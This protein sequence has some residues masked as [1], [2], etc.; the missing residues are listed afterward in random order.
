MTEQLTASHLGLPPPA[1]WTLYDADRAVGW[2]TER[3]VGFHGFADQTEAV[4]AAWVAYRALARRLARDEGRRAIPI[5]TEPLSVRRD[6]DREL[7]V[8]GGRAIA[9]LVRPGEQSPTGSASFGFEVEISPPTD[10]LRVRSLARL[11]YRTLRRSGLRW[12]LWRPVAPGAR[13]TALEEAGEAGEAAWPKPLRPSTW[14]A[15]GLASL[16]LLVLALL[17]PKGLGV[18]L[19][20]AGMVALVVFSVAAMTGRWLPQRLIRVW[21][22]ES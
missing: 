19:T 16:S 6:G 18:G 11:M 17:V 8:A 21:E 3:S 20:V 2:T 9:T 5:D 10:E 1:Q 15:L 14:I 12:A 4:H 7:I 22:T 13:P